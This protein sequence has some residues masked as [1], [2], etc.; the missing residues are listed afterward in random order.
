[1]PD[2]MGCL[3]ITIGP[4]GQRARVLDAIARCLAGRVA[5]AAP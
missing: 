5:A 2:L 3:R 4:A 1:V